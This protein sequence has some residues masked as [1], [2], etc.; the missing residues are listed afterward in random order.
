MSSSLFSMFSPL[1]SMSYPILL[2]LP[3]SFLCLTLSFYV[4]LPP[5]YVL[6]SPFTS[7]FLLSM[8]FPILLRL[9][10]S[11]LCLPYFLSTVFF[12]CLPLS[13]LNLRGGDGGVYFFCRFCRNRRANGRAINPVPSSISVVGSGVCAVTPPPSPLSL[14]S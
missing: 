11:F 12:L 13:L 5:F 1:L 7:S 14:P 4:F 9:L 10:S 6:L 3:S 2:R 8:S